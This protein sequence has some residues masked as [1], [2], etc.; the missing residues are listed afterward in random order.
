MTQNPHNEVLERVVSPGL[1]AAILEQG[2]DLIGGAV[3]RAGDVTSLTTPAAILDAWRLR[4]DG[5]PF[6]SDPDHVD[7][8][9]FPV[10]PLMV[11]TSPPEGAER[12]WPTYS[13]GF[14]GGAAVAP[15]W[16]VERT[17]APLGTELWRIARDGEQ[18]LLARFDGPA[19]GWSGGRGYY[20]PVHLVGARAKWEALD[21]P[22]EITADGTQIELVVVGDSAPAGFGPARIGVWR[23]LVPRHEVQELF[24]LIVTC[25]YRDVPCRIIQRTPE[26]A[27]LLLLGDDPEDV[28]RVGAAEADIGAF[29]VTVPTTELTDIAGETRQSVLA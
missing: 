19:D 15:V 25:R 3:V 28:R 2:Y 7:V 10:H 12:P 1:S 22:A 27:R 8:L 9:R 13:S 16:F 11:L 23:R 4:H 18:R 26:Q 20:P 6:A 5:S 14:L 21:V 29:E 24:E 17:R